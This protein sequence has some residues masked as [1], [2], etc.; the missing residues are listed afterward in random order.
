MKQAVAK[1]PR[2]ALI[3]K[4]TLIEKIKK[5][6]ILNDII[7]TLPVAAKRGP[8]QTPAEAL[9]SKIHVQE[10]ARL[11]SKTPSS[12]AAKLHGRTVP[13]YTLEP[14]RRY[15]SVRLVHLRALVDFVNPRDDEFIYATVSFL[16]QRF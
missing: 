10:Q 16:K 6:G 12:L 5:E 8:G 1:D 14:N 7:Q 3:D 2:L 13:S 15:L 9:T 11:E 4:N